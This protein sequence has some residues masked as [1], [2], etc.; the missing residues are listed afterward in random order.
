MEYYIPLGLFALFI[1]LVVYLTKPTMS[2]ELKAF[3]RKR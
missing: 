3:L 2:D 1:G